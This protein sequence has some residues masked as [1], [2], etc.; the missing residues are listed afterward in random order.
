ME[1]TYKTEITIEIKLDQII[2]GLHI[3]PSDILD[4]VYQV[5]DTEKGENPPILDK[6]LSTEHVVYDSDK[7]SAFVDFVLTD[8]D[9]LEIGTTYYTRNL[10][11]KYTGYDN[12]Y[13]EFPLSDK[14]LII[15]GNF[16]S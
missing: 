4:I 5:K 10:G 11:I 6:R 9:S 2:D 8:Y 14:Y 12:T 13:R 1:L 16:I 3:A 7:R 15:L